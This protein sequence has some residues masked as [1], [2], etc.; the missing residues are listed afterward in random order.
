MVTSVPKLLKMEANSTPTAPDPMTT[1]DLGMPPMLRISIL[2]R[3]LPPIS[4][5]GSVRASEPVAIMMF[6][7]LISEVLLSAVVTETEWTP[8]FAGPVSLP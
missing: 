5:P 8:D 1:S 6:F 2:E 3:T 7:A 4:T